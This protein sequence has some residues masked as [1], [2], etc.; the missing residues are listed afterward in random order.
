MYDFTYECWSQY[1]SRIVNG[2]LV[3]VFDGFLL[4]RWKQWICR[5][6]LMMI[7]AGIDTDAPI[8]DGPCSMKLYFWIG[9]A[10]LVPGT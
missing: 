6:T 4:L 9:V 7:R 1:L 8:E 10:C 3:T 2:S 5:R